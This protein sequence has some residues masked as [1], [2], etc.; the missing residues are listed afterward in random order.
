M[1]AYLD[2]ETTGLSS[3][4]CQITVIGIYRQ[5]ADGYALIQLVGD[6]ITDV[7]LDKA[8]SGVTTLYTYNGDRFD[9]EFIET[10][11]G[12]TLPPTMH[13]TDLM[14][15]CWERGWKGGLKAVEVRLGIARKLQGVSGRDAVDL[16]WRFVN[17]R[18][19]YALKKLLEYNSEDVINLVALRECLERHDAGGRS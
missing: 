19:D 16:W 7:N 3:L 15:S 13:H 1:D 9:L 5:T 2:I 6:E 12:Y 8:L 10:K 14:K 4:V 17:D 18:D 11:L